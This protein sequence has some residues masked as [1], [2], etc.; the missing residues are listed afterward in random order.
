VYVDPVTEARYNRHAATHYWHMRLMSRVAYALFATSIAVIVAA[1]DQLSHSAMAVA[2]MTSTGSV[3]GTTCRAQSW[4][5][6]AGS[7]LSGSSSTASRNAPL[8]S[9]MEHPLHPSSA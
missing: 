7:S 5:N 2:L 6:T 8:G 1:Q 9:L 3:I 4:A